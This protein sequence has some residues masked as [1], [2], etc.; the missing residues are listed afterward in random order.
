MFF[1][2]SP[3]KL[4]IPAQ[5]ERRQNNAA[6]LRTPMGDKDF[7]K[8][9]EKLVCFL[10]FALLASN[11]RFLLYFQHFS[12]ILTLGVTVSVS[13][14]IFLSVVR[15]GIISSLV[16]FAV[17]CASKSFHVNS[18]PITAKV[19]FQ[20][21]KAAKF[22]GYSPVSFT[23]DKDDIGPSSKIVV[24]TDGFKRKEIN[25]GGF[26]GTDIYLLVKLDPETAPEYSANGDDLSASPA[27]A[28]PGTQK[29]KHSKDQGSG[30]A[31]GKKRADSSSDE[32]A[33][34]PV[35]D[36]TSD[37]TSN[38]QSLQDAEGDEIV[39]GMETLQRPDISGDQSGEVQQL[40]QE[41]ATLQGELKRLHNG[42]MLPMRGLDPLTQTLNRAMSHVMRAQRFVQESK[43]DEA[44]V[45]TFKAIAINDKLAAAFALQGS[46]YYLKK[47]YPSCISA[48]Q[49][50]FNLDPSNTEVYDML[51]YVRSK[52]GM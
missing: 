32:N 19:Y 33:P 29:A 2:S 1:A 34:E 14:N 46:I 36:V 44:L 3:V 12:N 13:N 28:V 20:T 22:K 48:W 24:E 52:F 16:L 10:N 27:T 51:K 47:D 37:D 45:E 17:G 5:C 8:S 9:Q 11:P 23:I 7:R 4:E 30:E 21:F 50:A 25:V 26:D 15:Y 40:K 6:A 35:E 43:L 49:Q 31:S 39:K 42:E 41:L 38:D 18:E